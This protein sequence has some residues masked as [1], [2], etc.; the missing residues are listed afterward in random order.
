MPAMPAA[1]MSNMTLAMPSSISKDLRTPSPRS[2]ATRDLNSLHS[3]PAQSSAPISPLLLPTSDGAISKICGSI[4]EPEEQR[5]RWAC[6]GCKTVFARDATIYLKP[7]ATTSSTP[8]K[9]ASSVLNRRLEASSGAK[10]HFCKSCYTERFAI[11]NCFTC[12]NPVIGS[13]K[14]DG[15]F[16]KSGM[17]GHIWHG[18]CWKCVGCNASSTEKEITLGMD[19][20][21]V[22]E[23][24]FDRPLPRRNVVPARP[25]SPFKEPGPRRV[26]PPTSLMSGSATRQGM[27]AA[28]AELSRKFGQPVPKASQTGSATVTPLASP[29]LPQSSS[30]GRESPSRLTRTNS[31][32]TGARPLTAQFS[33]TGFNL[34]AFRP[35]T[36]TAI[37]RSDSRSRCN[38]LSKEML[39]KSSDKDVEICAKCFRGPFDGPENTDGIASEACMVSLQG[40]IVHYHSSCFYCDVCKKTLDTALRSFIRLDEGRFAHP[41]CAPPATVTRSSQPVTSGSVGMTPSSSTSS[42]IGEQDHATHQRL[43]RPSTQADAKQHTLPT[44]YLNGVAPPKASGGRSSSGYTPSTSSSSANRRFQPTSGA[45]PPTRSTLL[46]SQPSS[47]PAMRTNASLAVSSLPNR[48]PDTMTTSTSDKFGK[49]GG[50]QICCGC[51]AKTSSLEG[52]R[53]PRGQLWHRKCLVCSAKPISNDSSRRFS[54]QA[55]PQQCGK[56]LDSSAKVTADGQLRCRSC[57]DREHGRHR[58]AV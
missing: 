45:A 52:V 42:S 10:E 16:V 9:D 25:S 38:S 5:Q 26:S 32:T 4:I 23:E 15:K 39:E 30:F 29:T 35:T 14:E 20:R 22:C 12:C 2:S 31:F 49:L 50:M 27:G 3:S 53:G 57:Y 48:G 47:N 13:T 8:L 41:A 54:L 17:D 58:V 43:P 37:S 11:G 46:H 40:G 19:G 33:G 1:R 6:N 36:P 51:N 56:Q 34:A 44:S 28:I 18:R 24:C 21:P 7:S 55:P